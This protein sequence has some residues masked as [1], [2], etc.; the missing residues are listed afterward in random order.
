MDRT[1]IDF[2]RALRNSDVR[3]S[4]SE[5]M[6]A[7]RAVRL[8]GYDERSQLKE[9]LSIT[10][11]KSEE[12]KERLSRCFDTFFQFDEF[13][14]SGENGGADDGSSQDDGMDAAEWDGE[15]S[16]LARMLLEN[17]SEALA[18]A[19]QE[20][21]QDVDISQISFFI[22]RGIYTRRI[23]ERMGLG[24][25]DQEI[26]ALGGQDGAG[27]Q[28]R[29]QALS[30]ERTRLFEE[31]RDFVER[32]IILYAS[33]TGR[34]LREDLLRN[35][36][37]TNVDFSDFRIM[38]GLV[39]KMAR[40]LASLHSR[41][42][43]ITRRGQLDIRKTLRANMPY[44]GVLIDPRW[45][46]RKV[47]RPS[48]FAV[49][50]VSGSVSSVARFLLMF[51]YSLREVLPKVR[52]FAFS[53]RLAEVTSIM[54][55]LPLEEA[56]NKVL[57]DLGYGTTDY[58]QAFVDLENICME[59]IDR[60]S[61]VIILG[62]A[63]SNYLNPRA[64]ILKAIY[65]RAKWVMFLNP[66]PRSFWDVGDSEMRALRACCHQVEVCNT[67]THLERVIDNILRMSA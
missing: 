47:E 3:V 52:A 21:A 7:F 36:K 8:I 25:L 23:M 17:D 12:E 55:E 20:A 54:E 48:V 19:L 65:K 10:L 35:I 56:I 18:L 59:D 22:Q 57:K 58:G 28:S 33:T 66:E 32:Q 5:S 38:K 44:N 9:A 53:S 31:V 42:R 14:N 39:N 6:D 26:A 40:R 16:E 29:M 51:L 13:A 2:I 60:R 50:D 1:L 24:A 34:R 61:S 11:A 37:L 49:C 62:D 4:T 15:E 64:D 30:D 67:V 45:K 43:K 27:A 41:R 63:R 46:T